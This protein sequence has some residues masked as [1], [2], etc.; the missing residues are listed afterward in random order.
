MQIVFLSIERGEFWILT[1]KI[2]RDFV[3]KFMRNGQWKK[4][5]WVSTNLLKWTRGTTRAMK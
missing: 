4:P 3:K 1:Y 2:P 5:K